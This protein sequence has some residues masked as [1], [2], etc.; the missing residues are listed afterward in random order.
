MNKNIISTKDIL[1]EGYALGMTQNLYEIENT[2]D[3]LRSKNIKNFMEI[4]TNEGGTFLCW[5]RIS[6]PNG[7]KISLD[8]A[9]GPW[10]TTNFDVNLRNEKLKKLG[11]EVHIYDGNSH[12]L[13]TYEDI[14]KIIGDRK[15]DFLFIDGDHSEMGVKLDF[16]MYKEFVRE[17]GVI[18]FHDIKKT[19][20]HERS[21]CMVSNMW[22][23]LNCSRV[24]YLSDNE[25]G[26]IGLIEK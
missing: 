13:K 2:I 11:S 1:S 20:F 26:G 23:E 9:H 17:G 7:L 16:F 6:D 14:K 18:G 21:G 4:G 12:S 24:W 15:L 8:W 3:F 22:E 19:E 25:W 10:G 5:S